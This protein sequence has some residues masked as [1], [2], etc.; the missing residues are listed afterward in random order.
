MIIYLVLK[1][2]VAIIGFVLLPLSTITEL[3]LGLDNALTTVYSLVHSGITVFP[4]IGIAMGYV[5]AAFA[6]E[7]AF[8]S[9]LFISYVIKFIR[10]A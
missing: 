5:L 8:Y 1:F 7:L 3:P 10:G 2:F 4:F 9:W 6:I